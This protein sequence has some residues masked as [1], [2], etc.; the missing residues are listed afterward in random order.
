MSGPAPRHFA[1]FPCLIVLLLAS[2][3]RS[4]CQA[5]PPFT[6]AL[7]TA[8]PSGITVND[9]IW[10]TIHPARSSTVER[11]PAV[12][13]LHVLGERNSKVMRDFAAYLSE[14]GVT[15]VRMALPYHVQRQPRG[16]GPFWRYMGPDIGR[17]IESMKQAL[18]DLRS[19][20][21]WLLRQS[22]VD[23]G[24]LGIIGIS[25]GAILA[26]VAMGQDSRLKAGSALL[27]GGDLEHIFRSSILIDL[28][29]LVRR[30]P[31]S[32]E[33]SLHEGLRSVDPLTYADQNQPR[34]V[35]MIQAARDDIVVPSSA[36]KLWRALG[37]P[38]IQWVDVNHYGLAFGARSAMRASLAYL[39]QVWNGTPPESVKLPQVYAPVVKVGFVSGMDTGFSPALRIQM[40]RFFSRP[41]R[42]SLFHLDA[43]I[44]D[45]GPFAALGVTVN[46]YI[47][48][49]VGRRLF[50]RGFHIFTSWHLVL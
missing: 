24:R 22:Y 39:E 41:D 34:R 36:L 5:H 17:N 45:R 30:Y 16:L 15:V 27:G 49:G 11:S 7:P 33:D 29:R 38:P 43:G 25:L 23:P 26:H 19:A 37:K 48:V 32:F 50:G 47:D 31:S 35:L 42:I 46:R 14:R 20:T 8:R 21:D 40:A 13:L 3:G 4:S 10:L 6:V 12:L 1:R 9:L 28:A 2:A 44:A 18:S